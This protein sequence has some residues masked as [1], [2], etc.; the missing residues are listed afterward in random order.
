MI[1]LYLKYPGNLTQLHNDNLNQ[2]ENENENENEDI[3]LQINSQ[4]R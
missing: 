1:Y 4:G 3:D 2:N